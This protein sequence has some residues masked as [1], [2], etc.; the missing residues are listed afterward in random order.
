MASLPKLIDGARAAA[1]RLAVSEGHRR[2][3][4]RRRRKASFF[5]LMDMA[6]TMAPLTGKVAPASASGLTME[7]GVTDGAFRMRIAMPAAHIAEV[8]KAMGGGL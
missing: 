3:E 6:Q 2:H 4:R 5:A 1:R 8:G 7:G